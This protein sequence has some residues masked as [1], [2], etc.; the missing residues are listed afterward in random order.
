MDYYIKGVGV[1]EILFLYYLTL[2]CID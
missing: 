2:L 1:V